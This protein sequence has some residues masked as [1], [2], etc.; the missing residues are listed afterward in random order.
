MTDFSPHDQWLV[1]NE[2]GDYFFV[3]NNSMKTSLVNDF[4]I[5]D[6]K[7]FVTG[8]PLSSKFSSNFDKDE[9]YKMFNLSPNKKTILFLLR[10]HSKIP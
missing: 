3:S 6:E 4:K 9:I 8:I 7:V 1:G 5:P 2:Y 10:I